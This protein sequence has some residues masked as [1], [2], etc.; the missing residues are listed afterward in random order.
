M[1]TAEAPSEPPPTT[2]QP[3][4]AAGRRQTHRGFAVT[5]TARLRWPGCGA[6]SRLSWACSSCQPAPAIAARKTAG[7]VSGVRERDLAAEHTGAAPRLGAR[8]RGERSTAN[9]PAGAPGASC[10]PSP[11]RPHCLVLTPK[12]L[13]RP[14]VTG[15][16]ARAN[17][18]G[19]PVSE[20]GELLIV[21]SHGRADPGGVR[22]QGHLPD[23]AVLRWQRALRGGL[24]TAYLDGA[25]IPA[26]YAADLA[27]VSIGHQICE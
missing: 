9:A 14:R 6:V 8:R 1:S 26:P 18:Q 19:L 17:R 7:P 11:L 5:P 23:D 3:I 13:A 12:S 25:T 21:Y 15:F 10:P 24:C 16:I 4:H 27:S 22:R 20:E 2:G